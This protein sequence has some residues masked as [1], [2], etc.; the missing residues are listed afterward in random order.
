MHGIKKGGK[1]EEAILLEQKKLQKYRQ[2][3][4]KALEIIKEDR[5]DDFALDVLNRVQLINCEFYTTWNHRRIIIQDRWDSKTIEERKEVIQ[6]ELKHT[7]DAISSQNPKAYCLWQHRKWVVELGFA[8]D[9]IDLL[10]E[11]KLCERLFMRDERNFH[12]WNYRRHILKLIGSSAKEEFDFTSKLIKD[13]F[14]NYSGF[15]QRMNVIPTLEDMDITKLMKEELETVQQAVFTEPADQAP[16]MYMRWLVGFMLEKCKDKS[17]EYEV[18]RD[19]IDEQISAL[20]EL[21]EFEPSKWVC[22]TLAQLLS[23]KSIGFGTIVADKALIDEVKNLFIEL[24]EL[25]SIHRVFYEKCKSGEIDV[26]K[27]F[28]GV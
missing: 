25:D 26:I 12:C 1:S 6:V 7:M 5:R 11:L 20:E 16:W 2:L 8:E 18:M 9:L 19:L 3:A 27:V 24:I 28:F 21:H 17:M 15:H 4:D 14:S 22:L 13:N 10:F 23:L